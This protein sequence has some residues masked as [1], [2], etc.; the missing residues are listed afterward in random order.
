[1]P[2]R[3]DFAGLEGLRARLA[4]LATGEAR[5]DMNRVLGEEA[6]KLIDDGFRA[7]RDPYG[8][9]WKPVSRGGQPLRDTGVLLNSLAPKA[10]V[11]GFTVATPV[12]YA[13]V[14]Q[15]GAVIHAK[16]SR[17]LRFRPGGRHGGGGWVTKQQV[18][19]PRR[20]YMPEGTIGPIW[21]PS[22]EKAAAD[23][24]A[25]QMGGM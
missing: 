16:T 24:L 11:R 5:L 1:M 22:I 17:G 15:Y 25:R 2:V 12:K 21:G 7:G 9:A 4:H 6:A 23:H 8:R 14:H 20:Q 13:A 10:D 18:T 3:G 19:I